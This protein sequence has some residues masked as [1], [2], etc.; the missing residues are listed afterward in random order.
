MEHERK[1][2]EDRR[3]A[4]EAALLQERMAQEAAQQAQETY[5][6]P[7]PQ[8]VVPG[9]DPAVLLPGPSVNVSNHVEH[10]SSEQSFTCCIN[11]AQYS[12]P[13]YDAF[14]DCVKHGPVRCTR[15]G[16]CH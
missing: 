16:S 7:P 3:R 11:G 6:Q 4:A 9:P 5:N 10:R 1:I 14:N 8:V 13:D 15:T 12:C 2:S